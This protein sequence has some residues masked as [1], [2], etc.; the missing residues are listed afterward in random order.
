MIEQQTAKSLKEIQREK[1]A[2]MDR[3]DSH[4]NQHGHYSAKYKRDNLPRSPILDE[5]LEQGVTLASNYAET[6]PLPEKAVATDYQVV[7]IATPEGTVATPSATPEPS[8]ATPSSND[9]TPKHGK[10]KEGYWKEYRAKK[11]AQ[12]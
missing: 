11:K 4:M 2:R 5:L 10:H 8:S 3:Y 12:L 7:V 9:A 6:H 1:D